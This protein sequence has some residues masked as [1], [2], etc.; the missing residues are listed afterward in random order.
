MST[1]STSTGTTPGARPDQLRSPEDLVSAMAGGDEH[2]FA[3]LYDHLA[4]AV[5]GVARSVV[6]DHPTA[7]TVVE[8]TF[9][10][11]WRTAPSYHPGRGG[12]VAWAM[13]VAH[14]LAVAAVR[15]TR[16]GEGHGGVRRYGPE[17]PHAGVSGDHRG[18]PEREIV[19]KGLEALSEPDRDAVLLA[20]Y[21]ARTYREM[22]AALAVEPAAVRHRMR[23][24]LRRLGECL[25]KAD[26]TVPP[27]TV[28]QNARADEE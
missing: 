10:E 27:R 13:T 5:L 25:T 22:A 1:V 17:F 3:A 12:P 11:L 15:S 7:E 24:G 8:E 19:H 23:E 28:R 6:R 26:E 16:G 2:A 18:N 14:R 20:Y 9:V 4:P 21:D